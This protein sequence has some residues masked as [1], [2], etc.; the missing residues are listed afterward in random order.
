MSD[1]I[2]GFAFADPY[3]DER[4]EHFVVD[5][6]VLDPVC[7]TPGDGD[8]ATVPVIHAHSDFWPDPQA[9]LM[10]SS[11]LA[12]PQRDPEPS[13]ASLVP[14]ARTPAADGAE[15]TAE[16]SLTEAEGPGS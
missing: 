9:A 6:A 4:L 10:T 1:Y 14:R 8:N 16:A 5:K 2:G 15:Q 12:S 7:V 3:G 11:L 13:V